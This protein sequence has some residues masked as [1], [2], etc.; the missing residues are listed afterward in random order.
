MY[1]VLVTGGKQY[2]VSE[3]DVL[4]VEKL[5][6]EVDSNVD[7]DNILM[8]SKED[9]EL[10]VGKPVVEGANV[11]AKVLSQGKDKKIIV[12]KFKRKKDYRRK[13]GHRQPHTK[14]Q[15]EKINA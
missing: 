5:E 14:I 7:F 4:Y 2:K 13:A 11:S 8:V 6:A 3:G 1:A 12:F 15:I 9:G 10:V